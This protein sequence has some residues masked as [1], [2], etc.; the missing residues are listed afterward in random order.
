[1][2]HGWILLA[3]HSSDKPELRPK[4]FLR[5]LFG[6][7]PDQK[8]ALMTDALRRKRSIGAPWTMACQDA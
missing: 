8:N 1:M 3:G 4:V 6:L 7:V 5:A 2:I